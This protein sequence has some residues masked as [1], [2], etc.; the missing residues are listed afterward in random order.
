[1]KRALLLALALLPLAGCATGDENPE[2][3]LEAFHA[4]YGPLGRSGWGYDLR[5]EPATLQAD[6]D[7]V[8]RAAYTL[9]FYSHAIESAGMTFSLDAG[10]N[11]VRKSTCMAES[12]CADH[13]LSWPD[14]EPAPWGVGWPIS[15]PA[16]ANETREGGLQVF[17]RWGTRY[18]F[19]AGR[20]VPSRVIGEESRSPGYLPDGHELLTYTANGDLG[21]ADA[22]PGP[23]APLANVTRDF[24]VHPGEDQDFLGNGWTTKDAMDHLATHPEA[25]PIL[26]EGGCVLQY[27]V[28]DSGVEP[29]LVV[30]GP[31]IPSGDSSVHV[32]LQDHKGRSTSWFFSHQTNLLGPQFSEPEGQDLWPFVGEVSCEERRHIPQPRLSVADAWAR[33]KEFIRSPDDRGDILQVYHQPPSPDH[34]GFSPGN[35]GFQVQAIFFPGDHEGYASTLSWDLLTGSLLAVALLDEDGPAPR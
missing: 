27:A 3:V 4:L 21:I 10:F 13:L 26:S 1:M 14:P 31:V 29:I 33:S 6:R 30:P 17:T 12:G 28:W 34:G 18:E 9:T 15:R 11:V 16:D 19:E 5:L 20:L 24:L 2:P 35:H 22:W 25:G 23:A 32:W 7:L 8:E